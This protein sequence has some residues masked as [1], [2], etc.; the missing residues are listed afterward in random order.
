MRGLTRFWNTCF[1]ILF[2]LAFLVLSSCETSDPQEIEERN[3]REAAEIVREKAAYEELIKSAKLAEYISQA[4]YYKN[5]TAIRQAVK[6]GAD[7]NVLLPGRSS[8]STLFDYL[9]LSQREDRQI[10]DLLLELGFDINLKSENGQ[11]PL[12]NNSD[13]SSINVIYL[14]ENGADV[15]TVDD[16][17]NTALSIAIR[18][19]DPDIVELLIKYNANIWEPSI[20]HKI[21]ESEDL[22]DISRIL[23]RLKKKLLSVAKIGDFS[24]F[25]KVFAQN[26]DLNNK[27][28]ESEHLLDIANTALLNGHEEISRYAIQYLNLEEP[29][30]D[31]VHPAQTAVMKG[32]KEV[33]NRLF[34]LGVDVN[35]SNEYHY[36]LID[37][38]VER[39]DLEMVR[40]LASKGSH[41][42]PADPDFD[43][44]PQ[45]D[46]LPKIQY[47][48]SVTG[49]GPLHIAA[50]HGHLEIIRYLVG[51]GI[52]VNVDSRYDKTSLG[53]A[54]LQGHIEAVK[55]LI[56]S[57]A[58]VNIMQPL[59]H[60]GS[61]GHLDVIKI[62]IQ[63]GA[64]IHSNDS[65][66]SLSGFITRAISERQLTI[67]DWLISDGHLSLLNGAQL[68]DLLYR[69][70]YFGQAGDPLHDKL[71]AY[72]IDKGARL[73]TIY[74]GN[75]TI[76][77]A[78]CK[79]GDLNGIKLL[80]SH[81]V[82]DFN[83]ADDDGESPF[84][85]LRDKEYAEITKY[86]L[87]LGAKTV[88]SNGK[89]LLILP[90]A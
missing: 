73:D 59:T 4:V 34:K 1:C 25:K 23:K 63:A 84:D 48:D 72:A 60:A 56:K 67:I 52:N 86:L 57:G 80:L 47:Q 38:A 11:T 37:I 76:L 62:L 74:E 15:N 77:H 28:F 40:F 70:F 41:V 9:D 44:L 81:G 45:K 58:D 7:V 29:N 71:V 83:K 50:R 51:L 36:S 3:K 35:R 20:I 64:N 2:L 31:T 61:N 21:K 30:P 18:D 68:S 22:S 79:M 65:E 17:G 16:N 82:R 19:N 42:G 24:S 6:E 87:G 27:Y 69:L 55:L 33:L 12:M 39:N 49:R 14:L 46:K 85:I 26:R 88:Q 78:A 53:E 8:S 10:A 13:R 54:A 75:R 43:L 32:Y 5:Q 89:T 66:N 90:E